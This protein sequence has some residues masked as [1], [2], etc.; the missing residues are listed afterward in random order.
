MRTSCSIVGR[1]KPMNVGQI[2][3]THLAGLRGSEA[4]RQ[5]IDASMQAGHQAADGD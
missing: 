1:A 3:E 4:H 5:T 2:L